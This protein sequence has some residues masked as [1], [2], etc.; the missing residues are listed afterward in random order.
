MTMT[1]N[2]WLVL[3]DEVLAEE[4]REVK[5]AHLLGVDPKQRTIRVKLP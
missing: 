5:A 1:L 4:E 2:E 3:A